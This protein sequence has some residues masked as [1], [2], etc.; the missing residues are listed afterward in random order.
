[1][2]LTIELT[3]AL[4]GLLE[5]EAAKRGQAPADFAR[6]VLEERLMERNRAA[7]ALLDRW[8]AEDAASGDVDEPWPE[9][10]QA[11]EESYS[12]DRR[13]FSE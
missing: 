2:T 8:M 6:A 4:E 3:P 13:L 7:I 9:L 12:S 10:Q 5:N 11:L 1:M